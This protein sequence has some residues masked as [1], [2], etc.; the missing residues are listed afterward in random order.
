MSFALNIELKGSILEFYNGNQVEI[1][2]YSQS[3]P[4][5]S[6]WPVFSWIH[7]QEI[8]S[9][10]IENYFNPSLSV[11]NLSYAIKW[12]NMRGAYREA[13]LITAMTVL[14]NLIDSNLSEEETYLMTEKQFEKL[15]KNLRGRVKE[16]IKTWTENK[17]DQKKLISQ[18]NEKFGDLRRKSLS[19]DKTLINSFSF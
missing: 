14:E 6:I 7:L 5:K 9:C 4:Q 18:V 10:A 15:R 17:E 19:C 8:F 16:E 3:P 13:N 11:N 1:D 12:F 2:F